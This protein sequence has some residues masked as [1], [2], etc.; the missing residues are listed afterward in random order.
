MNL[1]AVTDSQSS[2]IRT[3]EHGFFNR[4]TRT[5]SERSTDQVGSM[6]AANDNVTV[7]SDKDMSVAGSV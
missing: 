4:T 6:V 3:I 5:S 2:Y 7:V 1:N